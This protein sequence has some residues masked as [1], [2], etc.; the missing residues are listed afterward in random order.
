MAEIYLKTLIYT[1]RK[2]NY[3]KIN[4][5]I[6]R[7]YHDKNAES[8]KR[9]SWKQQEEKQ[10]VTYKGIRIKLTAD[11]SSETMEARKQ[12]DKISEVFTEQNDQQGIL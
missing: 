3:N 10:I 1:S 12:W 2:L 4:T 8:Q 6:H 5:E 11:F 9:K 7:H